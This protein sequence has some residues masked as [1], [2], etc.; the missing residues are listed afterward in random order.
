[1]QPHSGAQAN[2]AVFLALLQPGDRIMGLD[3]AHGGHLTHGSPVTMS[4]KWF[5][6][7][8][9]GVEPDTLL[10]DMAKVR[11]KALETRPKLIIAGASAYPRAMD[12]AGFR[13]IADEVGAL[14]M[15]DMAHYAGLVAA[16][17]YPERPPEGVSSPRPRKG[18]RG[19]CPLSCAIAATIATA[20][21]RRARAISSWSSPLSAAATNR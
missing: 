16:G 11:A 19:L 7:V 18:R 10:I 15:V 1:V 4:G 14:L 20:R 17:L 9:Y 12:F 3:L 2:Q 21:P 13:A 8:S 6:V 5:D